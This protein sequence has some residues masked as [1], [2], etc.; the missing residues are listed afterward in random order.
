[1]VNWWPKACE[2]CFDQNVSIDNRKE[3]EDH[4]SSKHFPFVLDTLNKINY[5]AKCL[6]EHEPQT[7]MDYKEMYFHIIKSHTI[8]KDFYN[9]I[10]RRIRFNTT[11]DKS[12]F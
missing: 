12:C 6:Y 11:T 1:M 10:K 7:F 2:I 5:P 9:D 3:F 8:L 4:T